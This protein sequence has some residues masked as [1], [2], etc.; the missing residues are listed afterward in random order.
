MKW[1]RRHDLIYL[2]LA[3]VLAGLSVIA[4]Q[5]LK[6]PDVGW[7]F[8]VFS[9]TVVVVQFMYVYE[10]RNNI[11]FFISD[12]QKI[13]DKFLR[14]VVDEK[15]CEVHELAQKAGKERIDLNLDDLFRFVTRL[16]GI[17]QKLEAVDIRIE[18]WDYDIR[19]KTY[20]KANVAARARGAV[21]SRIFVF[22]KSA[23]D[24]LYE[25]LKTGTESEDLGRIKK[26]LKEQRREGINVA[27]VFADQADGGEVRDFGIFDDKRV[28]DENFDGVGN[29]KYEGFISSVPEEVQQYKEI[30]RKLA[31]LAEM[32]RYALERLL[33]D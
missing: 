26:L 29:S 7:V 24:N 12:Y 18:R 30:Y 9:V 11:S 28:L 15:L 33:A 4:G 1:L 22:D 5:K 21:I 2:G 8:G 31:T 27:F 25:W 20:F 19:A 3:L 13:R 17:C 10:L 16:V 23:R 6:D 14:G 32:N